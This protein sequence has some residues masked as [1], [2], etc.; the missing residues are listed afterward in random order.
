MT[1]E[2]DVEHE[3]V[4]MPPVTLIPRRV[5]GDLEEPFGILIDHLPPL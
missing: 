5:V 2:Q 1:T 3:M 4:F